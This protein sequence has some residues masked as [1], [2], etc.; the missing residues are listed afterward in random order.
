MIPLHQ[1]NLHRQKR[2]GR[3]QSIPVLRA[4]SVYWSAY[5]IRKPIAPSDPGVGNRP[6]G[7]LAMAAAAV[8]PTQVSFE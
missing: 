4:F 6:V 1:P 8:S 7:A 5:G 2:R 3:F